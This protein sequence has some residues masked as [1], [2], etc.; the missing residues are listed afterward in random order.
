M[1]IPHIYETVYCQTIH[2][3]QVKFELADGTSLFLPMAAWWEESK[4]IKPG[5]KMLIDLSDW[6]HPDPSA[7]IKVFRKHQLTLEL[8]ITHKSMLRGAAVEKK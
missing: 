7:R 4:L 8:T 6:D 2:E 5:D 3:L 1:P